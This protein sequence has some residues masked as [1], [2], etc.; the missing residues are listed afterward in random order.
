V[1]Q[2]DSQQSFVSASL[3]PGTSRSAEPSALTPSSP[4]LSLLL[5]NAM[6]KP[7]ADA[8]G[9]SPVKNADQIAITSAAL[10]ADDIKEVY[11]CYFM[12]FIQAATENVL[13]CGMLNTIRCCCGIV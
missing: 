4:L 11:L 13:F 10:T 2:D 9:S 7:L 6:S 8:A 1:L 3:T 12:H 5:S